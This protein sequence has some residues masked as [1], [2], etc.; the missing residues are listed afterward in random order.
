[1]KLS[2]ILEHITST[3]QEEFGKVNQSR[4]ESILQLGKLGKKFAMAAV[5]ASFL[6]AIPNSTKAGVGSTHDLVS[7]LQ[8]ALKLEYLERGYYQQGL[9][10]ILLTQ[11]A[12]RPIFEQIYQHEAAHVEF[13]R[14]AISSIN[15]TT[16][17]S[18]PIFDYSA[19]GA[20]T[21]FLSY[22]QFLALAQAFEDT[23][24]RAYKGQAG[25]L[26]SD[27]AILTAALQ[28]HSVEARH[29][30]EVRRLRGDKGWITGSQ[31]GTLPSQTQAVYNGEDNV[32]Q[33]GVNVTSK[34]TVGAA[35]VQEAFD[36]PLTLEEVSTIVSLFE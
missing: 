12:D 35:A 23:G 8:F 27:D 31:I 13:L 14:S 4:R 7:V 34:T 15:N 22:P 9:N 19:Q 24:V 28:I 32:M 10:T 30:S 26:K 16:P 3:E 2:D 18:E 33:G 17:I 25:N 11:T 6:A 20:F 21:P 5:P 1:M 36:E 29:A